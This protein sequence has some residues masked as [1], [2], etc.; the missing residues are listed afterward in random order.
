MIV[1]SSDVVFVSFAAKIK[2]R[3]SSRIM[4]K[5]APTFFMD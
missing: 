2:V 1:M 4:T 5:S 3:D